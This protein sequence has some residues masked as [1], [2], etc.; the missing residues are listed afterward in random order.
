MRILDK[1]DRILEVEGIKYF[2][3]EELFRE[4]SGIPPED[5][6]PRIVPTVRIADRLREESRAP[7]VVTSGYR[8]PEYNAYVGGAPKSQHCEFR[9]MDIVSLVWS[10]IKVVNWLERQPESSRMGIGRYKSFVHIDTRG[11][12]ARWT[13]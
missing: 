6:L 13:G 1:L 5:Y 9:A 3:A 7:V 2:V 10:P 4:Y 11:W 12:H 8:D